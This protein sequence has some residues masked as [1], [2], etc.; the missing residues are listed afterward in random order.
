MFFSVLQ[1]IMYLAYITFGQP[2][3]GA[4][5]RGDSILL[6]RRHREVQR[7]VHYMSFGT[8]DRRFCLGMADLLLSGDDIDVVGF[9]RD[10]G[11]VLQA[12][13][14]RSCIGRLPSEHDCQRSR[15]STSAPTM[16]L[17]P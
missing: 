1:A 11:S 13:K 7:E 8:H 4:P 14:P 6:D 9:L 12:D 3:G 16:I 5:Y 10:K 15:L 2:I 17:S